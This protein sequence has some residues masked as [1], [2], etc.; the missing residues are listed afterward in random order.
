MVKAAWA[1]GDAP[2][3]FIARQLRAI[4]GV[5]IEITSLDGKRK[6]SQNRSDADRLGVIAGHRSNATPTSDALGDA[7][8]AT[9]GWTASP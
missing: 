9:D 5:E 6:L 2:E 7:M 8:V 1:V 4:V 3:D